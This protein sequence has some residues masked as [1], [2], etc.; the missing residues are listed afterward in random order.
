MAKVKSLALSVQHAE[1][2]RTR[3]TLH[4]R[5]KNELEA[6][7]KV[8][9][10]EVAEELRTNSRKFLAKRNTR[11]ANNLLAMGPAFPDV[12]VLM[13]YINPVTSEERAVAKAV[14]ANPTASGATLAT[15][16]DRARQDIARQLCSTVSWPRDPSV[17]AIAKLC[18]DYFEW[19]YR[20]RMVH[21]FGLWLWEGIVC[22]TL[23]RKTMIFDA[24]KFSFDPDFQQQGDEDC[25]R[26]RRYRERGGNSRNSVP[27]TG[28]ENHFFSHACDNRQSAGV[29]S[30]D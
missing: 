21:R 16:V 6:F 10:A 13:A 20:E 25:R 17:K 18:E 15:I 5:E 7:L 4:G 22:R 11:A 19:G 30:R 26:P 8:W 14:K 28:H 3:V 12:D 23:R 2:K 29:P 1:N 27:T 9:R 24:R